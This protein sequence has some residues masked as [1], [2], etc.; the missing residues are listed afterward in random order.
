MKPAETTSTSSEATL[1][2]A[3]SF[4]RSVA[5]R[6]AKNFY[7]A[8]RVLPHAKSD[9]MCAVYAFMRKADDLADD[10]TLTMDQRR[11]AMAAWTEA[12]RQSRTEATGDAVFLA[13]RDVQQSFGIGDD[14]LEQLVAGTTM[15]LYEQPQLGHR[16]ETVIAPDGTV[17]SDREWQGKEWQV[18]ENFDQL[19]RYCYLVASVVGL[20]CIR[21]FGTSDPRAELLAERTGV[22]FQLTNILRDVKEDAE[23][24]RIY[25]PREDMRSAE[26]EPELLRAVFEAAPATP[27]VLALLQLEIARAE[28]LY[29]SADELIPMIDKDSR[30]A[31]WMLAQ[32]YRQLLRRIAA[33]PEQVLRS[34]V[35]L[36]TVQKLYVLARG[37]LRSRKQR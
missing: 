27:G 21:I 29:L 31:M 34:R 16:A 32:I 15:D 35:S 25:L 23:R 17:S 5:R 26:V 36:P 10:E 33:H 1:R 2:E 13:L 11:S 28:A 18:Y 14:L 8:F 4:C 22:A 20:V 3:Y 37:M 12:W 30:A 19:Y 6:E 24:G 9:A 7:W